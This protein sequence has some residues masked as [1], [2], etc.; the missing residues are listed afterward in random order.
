MFPIFV[1]VCEWDSTLLVTGIRKQVN[2]YVISL[3]AIFKRAPYT[4]SVVTQNYALY[5]NSKKP[6]LYMHV[7]LLSVICVCL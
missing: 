6:Q 7:D 3:L 5:Q 4:Y 1:C 2:C